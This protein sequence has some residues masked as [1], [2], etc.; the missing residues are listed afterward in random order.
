MSKIVFIGN[1]SNI[2][3]GIFS[4][5]G[6]NQVRLVFD[7]EIPSNT[8]LLSGFYLINEH[9]K[10]IQTNRENYKY[11]YR[12]Y[13]DNP[14]MIELCNNNIEYVEPEP[15]VIPKSEPYIPTYEE[16]L[17]NK[18]DELSSICQSTILAGLDIDGLHY[19]YS[20]EDQTNL[21]EIFD[22]VKITGLPMGYH[23][24]GQGCTEYTAEE[25]IN[26]Y[27]Q[28]TM[29]KYCQQTYFN[30]SREYL[31]SLEN[32]EENKKNIE[33]Y[34]YGTPLVD[35]YLS[36]YN[37]MIALYDAQIQAMLSINV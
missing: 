28:L 33:S 25:L 2:Y 1:P 8:D 16:V 12:T 3:D 27:I 18:V 7:S 11:I 5:I 4:Q 14:L 9:N 10:L 32:T 17:Q 35:P 13:D 6:E 36:K 34:T 20:V 26:I 30:Q 23:A 15:I 31:E 19:S 22:T 21:K 24:D 29:N 37:S